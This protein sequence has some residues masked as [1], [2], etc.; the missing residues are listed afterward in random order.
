MEFSAKDIAK[1]VSGEIEGDETVLINDFSK[2]DQGKSGTLSFLANPK[3]EEYIYT[4]K[5][6]IVLV[7]QDFS[8]SQPLSS[9]L[10]LIRV[11]NAYE[12]LAHLLSLYNAI[13]QEKEGIEEPSFIDPTA[14][15]GNN[16]YIGAFCYVG[17]NA[18]V[19]DG[20]KLYPN[21]YIGENTTI[22]KDTI[23][24]SGVKVYHNCI[25]GKQCILHAGVVVGS[26]GF[27]FAPN[28]NQLEKIKHLG[29]VVTKKNVEI[30]ANTTIDK[31]SLGSTIIEDGVKLDNLIQIGHNVKIGKNT[32]IAGLTAIAG[33]TIIGEN[34][35][36]GGQ[37][38]ITGHIKIGNNVRIAGNSGIGGN[39]KDNLTVQGT[40]AFNKQDFQRS[41]I[42][43][44]RLPKI[45]DQ[46]DQI[47]KDLKN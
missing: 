2:I 5:A 15:I 12:K 41:Y 20:V 1:L 25:I 36:I 19:A 42:L 45:V 22:E 3:Y 4:T 38:A 31:A 43:F 44:K 7:N 11:D 39:I 29:N 16:V 26:D 8:P 30:G 32:A 10:T 23:L 27:G 9:T 34:C 40:Y 17:K 33:S 24:F 28:E 21:T 18:I 46:L 35:L 13:N 6:S 37:C 47:K 14:K